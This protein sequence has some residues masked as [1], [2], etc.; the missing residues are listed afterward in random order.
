MGETAAQTSVRRVSR[1]MR[2]RPRYIL[3]VRR[4]PQGQSAIALDGPVGVGVFSSNMFRPIH[5]WYPFVEG[6]SSALVAY[7][8]A[9]S[10]D[11]PDSIFDPFG[12]SGTTALT[13]SSLGHTSSFTEVNPYLAWLADVKVNQARAGAADTAGLHA[14]AAFTDSLNHQK[15]P[16]DVSAKHPLVIAD[17]KRRFFPTGVAANAVALLVAID[18]ALDGWSRDLAR[19]AVATALVPASSMIR[20]TDL[21]RRTPNDAPPRDLL[22]LVTSKLVEMIADTKEYAAQLLAP[23]RSLGP[24]ARGSYADHKP[25]DL[26]VTSPPYLNGTNY[27]RNS[28]LE[29]LALG[30]ITSEDEL[31]TLRQSSL[32]AGI[33]NVSR[34]TREA[35]LIPAVEMVAAEIDASAYDARIGRMVRSYF[36]DMF[37]VFETLHRESRA[38]ASL[39]LDI[40]DSRYC[41]INVRTDNLLVGVGLTA[42]W[43]LRRQQTLRTRRSYDG[44]P[45][46][47]QLL[48]FQSE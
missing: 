26:I 17:S 16:S 28:K 44:S 1:G 13:A 24:D 22:M 25:F 19:L 38:G 29:L 37:D 36:S 8:L 47:Q 5:R 41:G 42:G 46:R 40:G 6:F 9:E 32:T 48:V 31:K 4:P 27:C 3:T 11:P 18:A 15:L 45:L 23:S 14:L 2:V 33:N 30:F 12:G 10:P 7:A 39:F 21:R 35:R 20:R 34:A 43:R